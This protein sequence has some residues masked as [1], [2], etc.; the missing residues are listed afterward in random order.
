VI[1][2]CAITRNIQL[3]AILYQEAAMTLNPEPTQRLISLFLERPCWMIE[4][5]AGAMRYSI[6]TVRRRLAEVGYY[7]SFTHNGRWY[8]LRSIPRFDRD[9]LWFHN[10]IGFSRAGSLTDTLVELTVHGT[11]GMTAEQLGALLRC[12]CHSVLVGLWRQGRL[13]RR[14]IGRSHVYLAVDPDIAACQLRTAE[15][16]SA[17]QIPAEIEV[18][19]LAEFIRH[20]D[21]GFEQLAAAISRD[22]GVVVEVGQVERLFDRHG[23]KKTIRTG[24]PMPGWR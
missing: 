5:L 24:A 9:G 2:Y 11:T 4:P 20:S 21:S 23:L 1:K 12:R 15:G 17:K 18:L 6:P 22:N 10:D 8:T 13:Q 19:L 16:L 14:K 7:S 3:D